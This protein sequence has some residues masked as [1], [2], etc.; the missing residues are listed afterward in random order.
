M[1]SVGLT[2]LVWFVVKLKKLLGCRVNTDYDEQAGGQTNNYKTEE[3]NARKKKIFT[4]I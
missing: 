1:F 2:E 4:Y 3:N